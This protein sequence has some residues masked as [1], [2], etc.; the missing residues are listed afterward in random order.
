MGA[1]RAQAFRIERIPERPARVERRLGR[2]QARAAPQAGRTWLPRADRTPDAFERALAEA[3]VN[4]GGVAQLSATV[5]LE[6]RQR[7]MSG[8]IGRHGSA[9]SGRVVHGISVACAV[10]AT[11]VAGSAG[12]ARIES[13]SMPLSGHVTGEA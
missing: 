6:R 1:P 10:L 4:I 9:V 5:P 2:A 13:A 3:T 8:G 7:Q 11:H 12:A